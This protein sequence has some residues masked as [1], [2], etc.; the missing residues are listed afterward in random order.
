MKWNWIFD[1][2][3]YIGRTFILD[4]MLEAKILERNLPYES[5]FIS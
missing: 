1:I 4:S 2:V 3:G 5:N